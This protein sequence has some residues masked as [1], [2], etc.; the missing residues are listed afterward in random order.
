MDESIEKSKAHIILEII[1]YES[2]SVV[3][4]KILKKPTGEISIMSFDTGESLKE[5]TSPFDSFAQIIDGK[6]E[7]I[8]SGKSNILSSGESMIIPAHTANSIKANSRFKM[9]L[10]IIKSG[11]E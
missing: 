9:I 11:Y 2:H 10:T 1:E 5:R 3:T 4:K 7:I 8:I 6:C